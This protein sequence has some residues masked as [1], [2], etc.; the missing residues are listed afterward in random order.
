MIYETNT[1]SASRFGWR[2]ECSFCFERL[3]GMAAYLAT[4]QFSACKYFTVRMPSTV[5]LATYNVQYGLLCTVKGKGFEI[6]GFPLLLYCL[7]IFLKWSSPLNLLRLSRL[8]VPP[9]ERFAT[10]NLN[11]GGSKR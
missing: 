6:C 10:S 5:Q 8:H 1:S 4:H 3:V 7:P 9:T 2:K 11:D